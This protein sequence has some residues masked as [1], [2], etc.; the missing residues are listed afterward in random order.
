MNTR[1]CSRCKTELPLTGEFFSHSSINTIP[2]AYACKKCLS[3]VNR[4]R[5]AEKRRKNPPPLLLKQQREVEIGMRVC[6]RCKVEQT[7][8][9]EFFRRVNRNVPPYTHACKK[10]L[11]KS[12][13]ARIAEFR[14]KNPGPVM[15]KQQRETRTGMR[16]CTRCDKEK[17]LSIIYFRSIPNKKYMYNICIPCEYEAAKEQRDRPEN[18]ARMRVLQREYFQNNRDKVYARRR[19]WVKQNAVKIAAYQKVWRDTDEYRAHAR[20]YA[21]ANKERSNARRKDSDSYMRQL[22]RYGMQTREDLPKALI[23]AQREIVKIR[24]FVKNK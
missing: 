7:L 9:R 8:S 3:K 24:R 16:V 22:L 11:G 15:L 23:E 2:Y 14:R 4:A 12:D 20:A 1:V 19:K 10:C 21:E 17:P 13:K 6:S 5:D 18:K